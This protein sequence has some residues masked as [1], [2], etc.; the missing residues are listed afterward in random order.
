ML[1]LMDKH[2]N[3]MIEIFDNR[4]DAQIRKI[5]L[6]L[7]EDD[8]DEVFAATGKS[9]HLDIE[10][11]VKTSL[12][13]WIMLNKNDEAVAVLGVKPLSVFSN[14]GI[15]WLLGTD[16]LNNMK[17]FFV[18]CSKPIIEE[19]KNGFKLLLNDVDVRYTKAVR[20]LKWCGFTVEEP[21]P[22]GAFGLPFHK[23][24][25]KVGT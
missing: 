18:Q 19:M 23:F 7:R 10:V 22:F 21:K 3:K 9:P 24:Y 14:T 5:A 15:P 11:G 12:R 2:G 16:G 1:N 6:N 25:M 13:T 20:W 17:R 4:Y 8:F